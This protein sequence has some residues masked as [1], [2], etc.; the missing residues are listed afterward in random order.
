MNKITFKKNEVQIKKLAGNIQL[1]LVFAFL[2]GSHAVQSQTYCEPFLDCTDDDLIL[3]V[4]ISTLTNASTCGVDGY[5][6]FT[7]LPAP[8]LTTGT[9]YPIA[10]TV[11]DGWSNES[12]SVW[13]DYNSNG[14]FEASEFTFIGVGSGSVVNGNISI[15]SSATSGNKRMRVRVAAVGSSGAT[16]GLACDEDQ[17]YGETEDYTVNIQS[18][19]GRDDITKM[20]QVITYKSSGATVIETSYNIITSVKIYDLLGKLV[21]NQDNIGLSTLKIE[22]GNLSSQVLILKITTDDGSVTTKKI[23]N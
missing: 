22:T 13:I 19:A 16:S 1:F 2:A 8:V 18:N 15:P 6:D 11:G 17:E 9:S 21:Y 7:T 3:N 23:I 14:T 10:V 12:V 20:K 4:S 5:N